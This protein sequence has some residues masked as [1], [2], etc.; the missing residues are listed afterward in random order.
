MIDLTDKDIDWLKTLPC[1]LRRTFLQ[2]GMSHDSGIRLQRI[3]KMFG[4]ESS[5]PIELSPDTMN[6]IIASQTV[7]E[8]K[9]DE[10]G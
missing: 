5:I 7:I 6:H 10:V 8:K 4:S 9:V 1:P 3:R 2:T